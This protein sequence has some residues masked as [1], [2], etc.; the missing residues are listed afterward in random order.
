ML[1]DNLIRTSGKDWKIEALNNWDIVT[2]VPR[3]SSLWRVITITES[4]FLVRAVKWKKRKC[5]KR[6]VGS[7]M[8]IVLNSTAALQLALNYVFVI[9][10]TLFFH[11]ARGKY[12][13]R[14]FWNWAY[15]EFSRYA[16]LWFPNRHFNCYKHCTASP[17]CRSMYIHLHSSPKQNICCTTICCLNRQ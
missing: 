1:S 8:C 5:M 13:F 14:A 9:I 17:N 16:N 6:N 4:F 12:C 15:L 2:L 7:S 11:R 3:D 10:V